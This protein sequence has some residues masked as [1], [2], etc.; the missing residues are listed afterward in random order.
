[1]S[2]PSTCSPKLHQCHFLLS[3]I[4]MLTNRTESHCNA[5]SLKLKEKFTA[6]PIRR[7]GSRPLSPPPCSCQL[8]LRQTVLKELRLLAQSSS[9]KC[10]L[11]TTDQNEPDITSISNYI[12]ELRRRM[13]LCVE[14]LAITLL[15]VGA[16]TE[17][18]T[19][20]NCKGGP[21][22]GY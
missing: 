4:C 5:T 16:N 10:D 8:V 6:L 22:R 2:N 3:F 14:D 20:Q 13:T 9:A 11:Q 21:R 12:S 17:W 7:G 1:M 18:Q 15:P 19:K